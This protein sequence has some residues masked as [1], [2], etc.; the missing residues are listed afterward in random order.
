[1]I[2]ATAELPMPRLAKLQVTVVV[3]VHEPCVVLEETKVTPAGKVS[4][5]VVFVA[6][7]GPLFVT[8]MR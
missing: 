2:L 1:M 7:E 8:T 5:I 4:V 6:G 3:P